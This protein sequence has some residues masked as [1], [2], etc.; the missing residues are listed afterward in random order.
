MDDELP[1][2]VKNGPQVDI[3]ETDGRIDFASPAPERAADERSAP[4]GPFVQAVAAKPTRLAEVSEFKRQ[5]RL[6]ALAEDIRMSEGMGDISH[7]TLANELGALGWNADARH[8][9][10][11]GRWLFWTGSRWRTDD[12]LEHMTR[13]RDFLR[14]VAS[15]LIKV[16]NERAPGNDEKEAKRIRAQGRAMAARLKDKKTVAAVC[17]LARSNQQSVAV[18]DDFDSDLFLLGTPN[19]TVDLRTGHFRAAL[20]SDMITR[21]TAVA[22]ANAGERPFL[23]LKFLNRVFAGNVE[24]IE[25]M[26]RAAGYALTGSVS[27]HRLLFAFGGGR[28]GKG[29][30]LNT[31]RDIWGDYGQKASATTFLQ[32]HNDQHSTSIA[33]LRGARLVF[34]SELPKGRSWNE[35]VIKDLT[36][37]DRMRA[38]FMRQDDF[39]FM[40]QLTLF[41][42]GNTKPS[43]HGVDTAIRERVVLI[44][45]TVTIP[46]GERDP[47]L[48]EKLKAEWPAI[49][50]W[51]ID[52]AVEWQRRG[53][54][55]P[56]DIRAASKEYLDNEDVIGR[57]LTD[58]TE[59][60][61]NTVAAGEWLYETFQ[62]WCEAE[63]MKSQWS[64]AA[65]EKAMEERGIKR[66]RK[67]NYR[68]WSGLRIKDHA[69][70]DT[71][72]TCDGF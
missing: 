42:A 45:F 11:W 54:D 63:G 29:V 66:G 13:T 23:W 60:D 7:D 34:G 5:N 64:K 62:K 4:A 35:A 72:D 1:A 24:H 14:A 26:Q 38:R 40:P 52:G 43:F 47:H 67:N 32:S 20:R 61:A 12:R 57:F 36:G 59:A 9:A 2:W 51:A 37:G 70:H 68:G 8:V 41:I 25:F 58:K 28:N 17:D 65:F 6:G 50:R 21:T 19:G 33:A 15:D 30:F 31:L 56:V 44:P 3:Y 71:G 48:L 53:L 49:L 55:V 46:E 27:E 39:E 22:P 69:A 18:A 16:A 10:A